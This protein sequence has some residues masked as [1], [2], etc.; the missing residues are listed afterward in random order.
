[1]MNLWIQFDSKFTN[2]VKYVVM[3]AIIWNVHGFV[4]FVQLVDFQ[5]ELDFNSHWR[6]M[7]SRIQKIHKL[8]KET[9]G[10]SVV[11]VRIAAPVIKWN[12]RRKLVFLLKLNSY[13]KKTLLFSSRWITYGCF[14]FYI[15][16]SVY[17]SVHNFKCVFSLFFLS[18]ISKKNNN[19]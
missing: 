15:I 11:W 12:E 6:V 13:D 9:F 1:M 7:S 4:I 3:A 19:H 8:H 5:T 18:P 14:K 2:I 10:V 17:N 16:A